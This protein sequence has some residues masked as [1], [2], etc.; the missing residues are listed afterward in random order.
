MARHSSGP[1]FNPWTDAAAS[2]ESH[3]MFKRMMLAFTFLA[4]MGAVGLGFGSKAAAW[5]SCNS[6][7]VYPY[8]YANPY[9]YPTYAAYGPSFAYYPT[10]PIRTRPVFYGHN[11]GHH[12]HHDHH[13][14]N[15]VLGFRF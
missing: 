10:G 9:A 1:H 14:N 3:R 13:H 11:D 12:H 8:P 2:E 15:F 5:D 7:Y 6:G 4:A